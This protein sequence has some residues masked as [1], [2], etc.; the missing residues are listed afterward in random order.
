ML[1]D[2]GHIIILV[3]DWGPWR[4]V[5][6]SNQDQHMMVRNG[7]PDKG[8]W[9]LWERCKVEI[10]DLGFSVRKNDDEEWEISQWEDADELFEEEEF[11]PASYDEEALMEELEDIY[12]ID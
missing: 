11:D 10:Q 3:E 9:S 4:K 2:K 8:F 12:D 1:L 7:T 6:V 5:F